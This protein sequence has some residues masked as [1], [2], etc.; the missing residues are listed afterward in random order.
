MHFDNFLASF[1]IHHRY[2]CAHT[3]QQNGNVERKHRHIVETGLSILAHVGLP[4]KYWNYAFQTAVFIINNLPTSTLNYKTPHAILYKR[5]SNYNMFRIFGCMCYPLLRPYNRNKFDFKS[6]ACL[7]LGYSINKKGFI[8]LHPSGKIYISRD[9]LFDEYKIPYK[10]TPNIFENSSLPYHVS[11][12]AHPSL[13]LLPTPPSHSPK[14]N[15]HHPSIISQTPPPPTSSPN[16]INTPNSHSSCPPNDNSS[17]NSSVSIIA[18]STYH[19]S[20]LNVHPM[21]TRAK[22]GISKPKV[23]TVTTTKYS[24]GCH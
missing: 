14:P 23:W 2:I 10:S 17:D 6:H 18:S 13:L 5:D 22:S 24:P 20:T 16:T 8:C 7:F 15:D 12:H 19:A 1:G 4:L 3:H 21:T 9:V 11:P